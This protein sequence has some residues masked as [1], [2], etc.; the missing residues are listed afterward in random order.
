MQNWLK[1]KFKVQ[2]DKLKIF[3]TTQT[4][5]WNSMDIILSSRSKVANIIFSF[6]TALLKVK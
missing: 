6:T 4:T 2:F 5:R 3:Y 1:E